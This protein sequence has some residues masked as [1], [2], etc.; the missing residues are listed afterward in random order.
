MCIRHIGHSDSAIKSA[1]PGSPR[2]DTSFTMSA[3][4]SS[5]ILATDSLLES[6]EIPTSGKTSL[7]AS[8]MGITLRASSSWLTST[9]PGLVDS[10][11]T[12]IQS[13]PPSNIFT[14]LS[15]ASPTP[16]TLEPGWNESGVAF[17]TPIMRGKPL[18]RRFRI[19]RQSAMC[20]VPLVA[21]FMM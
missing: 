11:P 21:C 10:P 8:M 12:S 9:A 14:A 18:S 7:T 13:A 19:G 2:E 3:P 17:N 16:S 6:I 4:E 5:A 1:I 15:T 20:G